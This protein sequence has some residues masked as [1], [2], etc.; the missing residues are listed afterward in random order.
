MEGRGSRH[1]HGH[2]HRDQDFC[3]HQQG[4]MVLSQKD[5]R[6]HE[7]GCEC[8]RREG[9]RRRLAQNL[10]G[11]EGHAAQ[12]ERKHDQ[13]KGIVARERREQ[14]AHKTADELAAGRRGEPPC[15]P[16]V[17]PQAREH[18]RH[19]KHA[20]CYE[21]VAVP[22]GLVVLG[23]LQ[24]VRQSDGLLRAVFIGRQKQPATSQCQRSDGR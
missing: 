6:Q 17:Q 23:L 9:D 21:A 14:N 22:A 24:P 2:R 20:L 5:G 12:N 11:Q 13:H 8:R 10:G 18:T 7:K 4:R 3:A 16:V 19:G 1:N 15:Y